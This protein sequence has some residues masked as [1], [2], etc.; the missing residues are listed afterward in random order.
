MRAAAHLRDPFLAEEQADKVVALIAD[1]EHRYRVEAENR[2]K[3]LPRLY[4]NLARGSEDPIRA[5]RL[6]RRAGSSPDLAPRCEKE[7]TALERSF[8]Q[9]ARDR[10]VSGDDSLFADLEEA[11][12]ILT[13]QKR[14]LFLMGRFLVLRSRFDEAMPIWQSLLELSPDD[15]NARAE[16]DRCKRRAA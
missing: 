2:L 11:R 10:L 14:L 4:Y 16:L 5:I 9:S 8:L 1:P 12:P 6:F 13:D 15:T 7:A 3:A